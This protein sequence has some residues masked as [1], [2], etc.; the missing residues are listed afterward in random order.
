MILNGSHNNCSDI[1]CEFSITEYIIPH[2]GE[3]LRHDALVQVSLVYP[4]DLEWIEEEINLTRQLD[5]LFSGVWF[6]FC[7]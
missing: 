6:A 7:F 2:I 3:R 4:C 5:S 1:R